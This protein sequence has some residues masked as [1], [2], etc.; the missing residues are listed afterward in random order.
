VVSAFEAA[1][2]RA[3]AAGFKVIEIHAAHGYCCTSSSRVEQ[4]PHDQYGGSLEN[5]CG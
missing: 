2:R 4:P 5:A 1:V 3:L